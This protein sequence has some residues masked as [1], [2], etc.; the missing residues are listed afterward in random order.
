MR[1]LADVLARDWG[2]GTQRVFL[3]KRSTRDRRSITEL[4]GG[5][6]SEG[7]ARPPANFN[8]IPLTDAGLEQP[9][10]QPP[11]RI[12]RLLVPGSSCGGA[13][14]AL[15]AAVGGLLFYRRRRRVRQA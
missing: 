10:P 14:L 1:K 3:G 15:L 5:R 9:Q 6:A 2:H 8:S 11:E 4:E 13:I 12:S 7:A